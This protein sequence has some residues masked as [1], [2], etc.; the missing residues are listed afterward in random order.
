MLF[1]SLESLQTGISSQLAHIEEKLNPRETSI[2]RTQIIFNSLIIA[3]ILVLVIIGLAEHSRA[4]VLERLVNNNN[5]TI[6]GLKIIIA[7]DAKAFEGLQDLHQT[8]AGLKDT[9][10]VKV[11]KLKQQNDR[12]MVTLK[13]VESGNKAIEEQLVSSGSSPEFSN[14]N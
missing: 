14:S 13:K 4:K 3:G 6:E 5:Q 11:E 1:R 12:L 8:V 9:L 7:R 10:Q 2:S